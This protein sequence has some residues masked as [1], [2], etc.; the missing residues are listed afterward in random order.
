[1]SLFMSAIKLLSVLFIYNTWLVTGTLVPGMPPTI[2]VPEYVEIFDKAITFT[3]MPDPPL[4]M[5][6]MSG[7]ESSFY[8][9]LVNVAAKP[10]YV[11]ILRSKLGELP[12][13]RKE[14]LKAMMARSTI[15]SPKLESYHD[16][17]ASSHRIPLM[18]YEAKIVELLQTAVMGSAL[19]FQWKDL[20][21]S[22]IA[23]QR[24][25]RN[26]GHSYVVYMAWSAIIFS[27][28]AIMSIYYFTRMKT[29]E[30]PPADAEKGNDFV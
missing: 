21:T 28:L 26:E 22:M 6:R 25:F 29:E 9:A 5:S 17:L 14:A 20:R 4:D 1:M 23:A 2:T 10:E 24:D 16:V 13:M 15:R 30:L 8:E 7:L 18:E 19:T 12:A 27:I 3:A 11:A